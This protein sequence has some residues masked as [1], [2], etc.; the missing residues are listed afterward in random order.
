MHGSEITKK[1]ELCLSIGEFSNDWLDLHNVY[2][3]PS[4]EEWMNDRIHRSISEPGVEINVTDVEKLRAMAQ[5]L[6]QQETHLC[7]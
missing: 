1:H 3:L 5:M 2:K 7:V 4:L 6:R